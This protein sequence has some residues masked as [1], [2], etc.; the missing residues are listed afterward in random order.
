MTSMKTNPGY[1]IDT[2]IF[3]WILSASERLSAKAKNVVQEPRNA[4]FLSKVSYWEICLKASKGKLRLQG[5]WEESFEEE[6]RNNRFQWLE[7]NPSHCRGIIN[8]PFHHK[9]PFDRLLI[10]QANHENLIL[11]TCDSKFENYDVETIW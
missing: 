11:V 5:G 3:L 7:V 9:D 1:L 2:H 8:L 6:R 10:A 4:I